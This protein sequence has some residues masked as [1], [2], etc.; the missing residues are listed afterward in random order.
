MICFITLPDN[1]STVEFK[2]LPRVINDVALP[3]DYALNKKSGVATGMK[4][5]R[6]IPITGVYSSINKSDIG[7]VVKVDERE[8]HE[9]IAKHLS[10]VVLSILLLIM[11][12]I[13]FLNW[14]VRPLVQKLLRSE[15]ALK[16][17]LIED[18]CLYSIRKILLPQSLVEEVC[19]QIIAQLST[20]MQFPQVTAIK[21]ELNKRQFMCSNYR[22]D[23]THGLEA[24]VQFKGEKN[25]MLQVY[26]SEK[27]L[28]YQRN[29]ISS[30]L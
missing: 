25:G 20:A 28:F 26:Y 21:L 8:I 29:R 13:L 7:L 19:Q 9:L 15:Q 10:L 22:S 5:Y 4:D 18:T 17:R 12:G 6:Q 23:Y 30:I 11:I 3:M 16:K 1:S 2:H 27:N 24:E 14:L